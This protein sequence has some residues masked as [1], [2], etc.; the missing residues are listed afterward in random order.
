MNP[1][2]AQIIRVYSR[3]RGSSVPESAINLDAGG[4]FEV[5]IEA[6]AGSTLVVNRVPFTMRIEGFDSTSAN[7]PAGAGNPSF[8]QTVAAAQ[9]S[10]AAANGWPQKT[11]VFTVNVA[12]L[13]NVQDHFFKYTGILHTAG[14][15]P[16]VVSIL[17]SPPFIIL[18]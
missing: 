11:T 1:D 12:N 15:N 7:N 16:T 10:F 2:D 17:E 18:D 8:S 5:V 14:P 13:A 3:N 6:E 4:N 9:A